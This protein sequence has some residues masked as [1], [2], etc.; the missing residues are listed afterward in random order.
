[1]LLPF[2]YIGISSAACVLGTLLLLP[3]VKDSADDTSKLQQARDRLLSTALGFS[4]GSLLFTSLVSLVPEG[5]EKL[6]ESGYRY[7]LFWL[8]GCWSI[9]V[10]VVILLNRWIKHDHHHDLDLETQSLITDN[11]SYG[12]LGKFKAEQSV[13][14][15]LAVSHGQKP[16]SI[17]PTDILYWPSPLYFLDTRLIV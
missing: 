1:M 13:H 6:K 15:G 3:F 7:P 12:T 8:F 10:A 5:L 2:L 16:W 11:Y 17:L 4:A 9:G 14:I